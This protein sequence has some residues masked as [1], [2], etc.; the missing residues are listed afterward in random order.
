VVVS[1]YLSSLHYKE[2]EG[3]VKQKLKKAALALA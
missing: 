2:K 3:A 1:K